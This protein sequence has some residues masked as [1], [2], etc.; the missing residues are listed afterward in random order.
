MK[1]DDVVNSHRDTKCP[2]CIH[3]DEQIKRLMED[4]DLAAPV[5]PV[6][7]NTEWPISYFKQKTHWSVCGREWCYPSALL[8]CN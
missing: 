3:L 8:Q 5:R 6:P 4:K 7:L 1:E 2:E